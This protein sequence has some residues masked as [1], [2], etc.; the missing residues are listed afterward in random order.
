MEYLNPKLITASVVYSLIGIL[1]LVVS[2]YIFDKL[3]PKTLWKEIMEEH[4]TALAIVAAAFM[5]SVALIISSA[6]HG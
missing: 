2:F 6:I 5:L 3:T 1:I 4:N